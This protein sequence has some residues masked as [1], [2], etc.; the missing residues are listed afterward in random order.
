MKSEY[1]ELKALGISDHNIDMLR[2][3]GATHGAI[4]AFAKQPPAQIEYLCG[5]KGN[6]APM[7]G[8]GGPIDLLC[9]DCKV[10]GV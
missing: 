1:E 5:H 4:V 7:L 10:N 8:T 9:A 3:T 6:V 2:N